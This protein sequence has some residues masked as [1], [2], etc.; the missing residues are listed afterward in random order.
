MNSNRGQ[1]HSAPLYNMKNRRRSQREDRPPEAAQAAAPQAP[2]P[3]AKR[4]RAL[5]IVFSAVLPALFLLSL[6]IP[7]NP[8]RW[9]FLAAAAVSVLA[10]WALGAFV[11]SARNTLTVVYGALAVVIGLALLMNVQT[12]ESRAAA[13]RNSRQASAAPVPTGEGLGAVLTPTDPPEENREEDD[14]IKSQA[15]LRLEEFFA[16]WAIPRV[17]EMVK[18]CVPSWVSAQTSP[19]TTLYQMVQGSRPVTVS[20]ERVEGSDSDSTRTITVRAL[21]NENN[22]TQVWKRIQ[23]LM[24]RVNDV[25]YVGPQSLGGMVIDETAQGGEPTLMPASTIAPTATPNP[26]GSSAIKVYYNADGGKYYH[27][28]P[29]C[30]WVDERYWPLTAFSF[31]LINSQQFKQLVRCPNCNPPERPAVNR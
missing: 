1:Y 23:V 21:F 30:S 10:M 5:S 28:I 18:Y 20:V 24:F 11:Q 22:N 6:L 3:G 19:E 9:F 27:A 14:S 17:D 26:D 4:F 13:A 25:W 12:P 16:A 29:N 2:S 31:D 7:S 15:Q 8:L